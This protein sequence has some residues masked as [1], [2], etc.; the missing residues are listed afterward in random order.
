MRQDKLDFPPSPG[1]DR[2]GDRWMA[3]PRSGDAGQSPRVLTWTGRRRRVVTVTLLVVSV[4]VFLVIATVPSATIIRPGE[5]ATPHAQILA[6]AVTKEKCAACHTQASLS[7]VSW[8]LS[9][10]DSHRDVTQDDLCLKCHHR[11]IPENLALAAHNVPLS[12]RV[13][14]TEAVRLASKN[15]GNMGS[16]SMHRFIPDAAVDQ[17]KVS[18]STCHKEHHGADG[19][20][21]AMTNDQ[22]QTCHSSRFGSFA[23]SHPDWNGWPYGRGGEIAF[24]HTTHSQKHFPGWKS[25]AREFNC[26]TC[27]PDAA[28]SSHA[29]G[30]RV[31]EVVRVA[32]Y[33]HS[34]QACHEESMN[35]QAGEGLDFVS[36]PTLSAESA[37]EIPGW[38]TASIGFAD[39][40]VSPLLELL[41][42]A[43]PAVSGSLRRIP[44][45]DIARLPVD[46][47]AVDKRLARVAAEI[48]KLIN[49]VDQNGQSAI[50]ERLL[51]IGISTS[52]FRPVLRSL[53]PQLIESANQNWFGDSVDSIDQPLIM[54]S[55]RG[56]FRLVAADD[57][58]LLGSSLLNSGGDADGLLENDLLRQPDDSSPLLEDQLLEDPLTVQAEP[59]RATVNDVPA[60]SLVGLGGW[61]RDDDRLS[62]R[63]HGHGHADPVMVGMIETFAQLNDGDPLKQRFFQGSFVAACVSCH[64]AAKSIPS[65]WTAQAKIGKQNEF[66]KFSHRPHLNVSAL[67]D[68]VFCHRTRSA[69]DSVNDAITLAAV[70][71]TNEEPSDFMPLDRQQCADCHNAK[72]AG[73]DCTTCHRYH[74]AP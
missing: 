64:S 61:Y 15:S 31:G 18:C 53:P 68:C 42:R 51:E 55:P 17:N 19:D 44:N 32:S 46:D 50:E 33:K 27:H 21:R 7:P 43:D 58:D 45:G 16:G 65:R 72:A 59:M 69:K 4:V 25:G 29:D 74:L 67:G 30:A 14:L 62:I 35:I 54:A 41:L 26:A 3:S 1:G 60:A 38:P 28:S 37:R 40:V 56:R 24:S 71:S 73:D 34:C 20:L 70:S 9:A 48:R 47:P 10:G 52:V 11:M 5:L 6:G 39:G 22:C 66:T 36:L 8:F 57:G 23:K 63:Y 12:V 2:P 13:E 49:D